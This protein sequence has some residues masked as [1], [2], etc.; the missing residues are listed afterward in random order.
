[1]A[2]VY[3]NELRLEDVAQIGCTEPELAKTC[4]R[5]GD[6]LIVE[7]NG[8]ID[9]I[10]R[11]ALWND[12]ISGC[13]HQNHI[14]RGRPGSDLSSDYALCWLLSPEGRKAIEAVASSSSG[15]HTLSISKVEGLPIPMCSLEEQQ[16]VVRT[17]EAALSW[18]KRLASETTN[19]RKLI[20][21]LD[22]TILAKAFQGELVPQDPSDEPA[23]VLLERIG[24]E[25]EQM[26]PPKRKRQ[27]SS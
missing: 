16:E 24:A 27:R 5:K 17:I 22:R 2:N 4:L 9:Q 25:R 26:L 12:E 7:G 10:G 15:L 3:A 8:S 21:H 14:I 6:L 13:S 19:A 1:V 18:I 11:V 20:D 23:S